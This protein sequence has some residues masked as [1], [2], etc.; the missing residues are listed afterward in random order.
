MLGQVS[1]IFQPFVLGFQLSSFIRKLLGSFS[2][3]GVK[4]GTRKLLTLGRVVLEALDLLL[5]DVVR[6]RA[7]ALQIL[8]KGIRIGLERP[9]RDG[10]ER[11]LLSLLARLLL[12]DLSWH[13]S[14]DLRLAIGSTGV[15]Q[16][17]HG[18]DLRDEEGLVDFGLI[19]NGWSMSIQ[20]EIKL[21]RWPR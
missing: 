5:L 20:Y 13:L 17:V 15:Q 16:L 3:G 21:K 4:L 19:C 10:T 11:V 9:E 8:L 14:L 6:V 7:L 2:D 1:G 12:G 18:L